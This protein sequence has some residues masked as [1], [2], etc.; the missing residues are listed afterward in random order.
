MLDY[1]GEVEFYPY[2]GDN[3]NYNTYEPN[4]GGVEFA[5][6][7]TKSAE[8]FVTDHNYYHG[9]HSFGKKIERETCYSIL[10]EDTWMNI[11]KKIVREIKDTTMLV[12]LKTF[13]EVKTAAIEKHLGLGT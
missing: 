2:D 6:R 3:D 13:D 9:W 12:H 11:P 10:V 1:C 7:N 5:R 4:L 8:P